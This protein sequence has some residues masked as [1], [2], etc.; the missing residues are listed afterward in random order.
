MKKK[1][2]LMS[3]TLLVLLS[4]SMAG[5]GS[6]TFVPD[7]PGDFVLNHGEYYTW[8]IDLVNPGETIIS[9]TLMLTNI[10]NSDGDPDNTLFINLLPSGGTPGVL[11][12][13]QDSD[14]LVLPNNEFTGQGY[15][16]ATHSFSQS[17]TNVEH[18]FTRKELGILNMYADDMNFAIGFDSDCLFPTQ[19]ITL[20]IVTTHAPIPGAVWLLASGIVGL[21]GI[22]RYTWKR[23]S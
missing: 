9:A 3:A 4:I 12:S 11:V 16:L 17:P 8:G 18:I 21:V 15:L 23:Q 13:D 2:I 1:F 5:A 14:S 19:K 20:D 22:R 10:W 7:N 6:Y